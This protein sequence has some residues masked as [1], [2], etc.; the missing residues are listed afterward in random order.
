[1][2]A[3]SYHYPSP[4]TLYTGPMTDDAHECWQ[5]ETYDPTARWSG[6]E[7]FFAIVY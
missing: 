1:M 6:V 7:A 4:P 5:R 3:Q 2:F